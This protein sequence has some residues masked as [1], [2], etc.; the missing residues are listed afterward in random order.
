MTSNGWHVPAAE[1]TVVV[2]GL[3]ALV[4]HDISWFLTHFCLQ[5]HNFHLQ[6]I[7]RIYIFRTFCQIKEQVA[8]QF[9]KKIT[10]TGRSRNHLAHSNF[11]KHF[12]RRY[13]KGRCNPINL[14]NKVN[15]DLTKLHD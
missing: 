15:L 13:Q 7:N 4:S 6:K 10:R 11:H 2:D 14:Q 9:P 5:L 1:Y 3:K 8:T 12:Q